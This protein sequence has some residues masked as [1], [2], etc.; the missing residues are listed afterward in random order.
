MSDHRIQ[1]LKYTGFSHELQE[2][3]K[4][5]YKFGFGDVDEKMEWAGGIKETD[6]SKENRIHIHWNLESFYFKV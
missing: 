5:M 3:M 1:N 6:F 4:K 2:L